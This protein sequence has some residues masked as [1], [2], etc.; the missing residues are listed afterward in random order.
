MRSFIA[1]VM[2]IALMLIGQ[3]W[4]VKTTSAAAPTAVS[5]ID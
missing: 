5:L 1:S 3:Q 4:V 2:I